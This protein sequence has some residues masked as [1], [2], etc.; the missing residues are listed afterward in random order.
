MPQL[1]GGTVK[2]RAAELRA[3]GQAALARYLDSQAGRVE[4][5]LFE[6]ETL[7]RTPHFV[8]V[9]GLTAIPGTRQ[10]VRLI[11]RIGEQMRGEAA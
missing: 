8:P 6:E 10:K 1:P 7:G 11:E 4:E 9:T 2:A 3:A 5:I